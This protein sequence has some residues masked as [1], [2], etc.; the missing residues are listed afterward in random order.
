MLRRQHLLTLGLFGLIAAVA[1]IAAYLLALVVRPTAVVQGTDT[2]AA[3][4]TMD[5]TPLSAGLPLSLP[6]PTF[7]PVTFATGVRGEEALNPG[8]TFPATTAVVYALWGYQH[9]TGGLPYRL[10][11]FLDD[12]LWLD[13]PLAWDEGRFGAAGSTYVAHVDGHDADGLPPGNYRLELFI[14][15]RQ[16]QVATF[17]ILPPTPLPSTATLVPL[18][19]TP[20]PV[21]TAQPGFR[22]IGKRAARSLV[23]ILVPRDDEDGGVGG[24]GSIVEGTRGLIL[25]AWHLVGDQQGNLRVEGEYVGIALTVDLDHSAEL[26]YAAVVLTEHA[27]PSLDIALL[28]ITHRLQGDVLRPL[29]GPLDLPAIPLGD[30]AQVRLGDPVLQL[31]YPDY[32]LGTISWTEGVVAV[33]TVDWIKSSAVG[34]RGHSG[35][36]MLNLRGELIG[37]ITEGEPIGVGGELSLARRINAVRPLVQR[38]IAGSGTPPSP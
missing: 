25:T 38:A 9:L 5:A 7:G 36:M 1:A 6:G 24:S 28:R 37:V 12:A 33:R 8:V 18:P 32:A 22:E 19:P 29:E 23:Q 17:Q 34:G 26:A 11:W 3:K 10:S 14:A 20:P 21:S 4:P 30:S 15:D 13:E 35:G 27:D 16:V 2:A 31:G